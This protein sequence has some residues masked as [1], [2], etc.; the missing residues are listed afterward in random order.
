M[1]AKDVMVTQLHT[2]SPTATIPAALG[3]MREHDL[4]HLLISDNGRLAGVVSNGDCRRLLERLAAEAD[5]PSVK[6]MVISDIMTPA[7]SLVFAKWDTP[8][9]NIAQLMVL[10]HVKLLPVLDEQ[11]RLAGVLTQTDVMR[12]LARPHLPAPIR[13]HRHRRLV[14]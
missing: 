13:R 5:G 14:K 8:V 7:T 9:L 11:N 3:F 12:E 6:G 2:L 1:V 4:T 10:K